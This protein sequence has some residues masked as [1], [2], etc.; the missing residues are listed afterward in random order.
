MI[1]DAPA[2]DGLRAIAA[3]Y[4]ADADRVRT[5]PACRRPHRGARA[6]CEGCVWA[7]ALARGLRRAA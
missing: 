1:P 6:F 5:C 2:Y 4:R 3:A 7:W